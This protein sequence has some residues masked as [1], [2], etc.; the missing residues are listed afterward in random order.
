VQ[1]TV[2]VDPDP[3]YLVEIVKDSLRRALHGDDED[4]PG[5]FTF[6]AR[7]LGQPAFLS[8]VYGRLEA[9]AG[10]IGMRVS[11]FESAG[12]S[13]LAD[14]IRADVDEWLHLAPNDLTLT[15]SLAGSPA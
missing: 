5:M 10:V 4:A 8:E 3:A 13:A 9:V 14:V 1:L 12:T 15:A 6:P 2:D 11:R 7:E